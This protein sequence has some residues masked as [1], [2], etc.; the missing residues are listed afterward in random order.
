MRSTGRP[1]SH[2]GACPV[3]DSGRGRFL[4]HP[5]EAPMSPWTT[6][7]ASLVTLLLAGTVGDAFAAWS[8]DPNGNLPI[9]VTP[10]LQY[11]PVAIS[12]G[13]G[14]AIIAWQDARNPSLDIFAQ[15]VN[16]SGVPQWT[17]N[18]VAVATQTNNQDSAVMASDGSGG[19]I[20]CWQDQ[21]AGVGVYDIWGQHVNA[22]GALLWTA[23]GVAFCPATGN[24][25]AP[26]I[27]SDSDSGAIATWNNHRT[28]DSDIYAQHV[29]P[30]G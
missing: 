9:C 6:V 1:T 26:R 16:A 21:R 25:L 11:S 22:S 19:A 18:G 4:L 14:G 10:T 5:R 28:G 29:T 3:I 15:R 27:V 17:A 24:Q 8:H 12:D 20:L 7:R 23:C 2:A 30:G 13:A